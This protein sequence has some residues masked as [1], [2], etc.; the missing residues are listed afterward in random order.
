MPLPEEESRCPRDHLRSQV[1]GTH[2]TRTSRCAAGH[3]SGGS[4]YSRARAPTVPL[5]KGKQSD[6]PGVCVRDGLRTRFPTR[7][8][9][10][11]SA[12]RL[13]PFRYAD[14]LDARVN[15]ERH[16]RQSD[17]EANRR[18]SD[19]RL[20]ASKRHRT[21]FK[22]FDLTYIFFYSL[23]LFLS[24]SVYAGARF[25]PVRFIS[26]NTNLGQSI[27]EN[28]FPETRRPRVHRLPRFSSCENPNANVAACG[29]PRLHKQDSSR[30][31]GQHAA[32][33]L[34]EHQLSIRLS[35]Q[36]NL[37]QGIRGRLD[38]VRGSRCT[39]ICEPRALSL[40]IKTP[41]HAALLRKEG[42]G[43]YR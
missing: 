40:Q 2:A 37:S 27:N 39:V 41:E 15:R 24:S 35:A 9:P 12:D 29:P 43:R 6:R 13:V 18:P 11:T 25:R 7:K 5:G 22:T 3:P 33:S 8:R 1:A 26:A 31:A 38:T 4:T 34:V 10:Y 23:P 30:F 32:G 20:C 21:E 16:S 19:A 28:R 14:L 17:L 42:H 36:S